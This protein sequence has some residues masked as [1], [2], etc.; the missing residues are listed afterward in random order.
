VLTELNAAFLSRRTHEIPADT[1]VATRIKVMT[2]PSL[3]FSGETPTMAYVNISANTAAVI[4]GQACLKLTR[5]G[6]IG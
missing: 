3:P 1:K 2:N 6:L 5:Q 4:S